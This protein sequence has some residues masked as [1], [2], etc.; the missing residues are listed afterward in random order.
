MSER[1]WEFMSVL[2]SALK[3]GRIVSQVA[4]ACT[5]A[6]FSEKVRGAQGH[7]DRPP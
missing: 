5:N 6:C 4:G 1:E 7:G 2:S 3:P